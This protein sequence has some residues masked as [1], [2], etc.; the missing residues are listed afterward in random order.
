MSRQSSSLD[1]G[2][3][4]PVLGLGALVL[5]ATALFGACYGPSLDRDTYTV[6]VIDTERTGGDE[7]KFLIY[8][9]DVN[10]GKLRTFKNV[11]SWLEC[12]YSGCKR[13]SGTVQAQLADISRRD[14][15]VELTTVGWR[16]P[17]FSWYENIVKVNEKKP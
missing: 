9:K 10:S 1:S 4:G 13:D 15:E 16:V 6:K 17:L 3:C 8:T 12:A 2:C 5:G 7:S 11:D 14:V